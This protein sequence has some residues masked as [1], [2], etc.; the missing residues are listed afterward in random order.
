MLYSL[1]FDLPAD[2]LPK[3][4]SDDEREAIQASSDLSHKIK[5][6]SIKKSKKN[7]SRLPRSATL[8]SLSDMTSDMTRVGLDP[9]RIQERAETLAKI[10]SMKRKRSRGDDE[11]VDMDGVDD[12]SAWMDVDEDG[13]TPSAKRAKGNAGG[14]VDRRAPR[15]NRQ[16]DGMR[17]QGVSPSLRYVNN[18][19]VSDNSKR[20]KRSKCGMST[21]DQEMLWPKPEKQIALSKRRW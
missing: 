1:R 7:Q 15:T 5:S 12:E 14:V 18:S 4:D 11:D 17:D 20:T 8:R 2:R 13:K 21:S 16:L 3:F 6:Q 10:N 9:S 19:H